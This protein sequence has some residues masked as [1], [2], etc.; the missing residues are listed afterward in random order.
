MNK[1][2]SKKFLAKYRTC[3]RTAGKY[4]KRMETS[5]RLYTRLHWNASLLLSHFMSVNLDMGSTG[6]MINGI[7]VWISYGYIDLI[8]DVDIGMAGDIID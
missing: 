7:W 6:D 8:V 2:S 4:L 1:R 5:L 3:L